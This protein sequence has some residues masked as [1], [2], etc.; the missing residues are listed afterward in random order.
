[1]ARSPAYFMSEHTVYLEYKMKI[2]PV[3][4]ALNLDPKLYLC[5]A[6]VAPKLQGD[7][8]VGGWI[9][10]GRISRKWDVGVWTGLGWPRIETG[11]GRL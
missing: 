10:F 11:G 3:V 9:I 1:M 8:G 5:L 6:T 7:L 4:C 2:I